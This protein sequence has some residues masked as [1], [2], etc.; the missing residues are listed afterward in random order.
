MR[1]IAR[2]DATAQAEFVRKGEITPLELVD[3]AIARIERANPVLNAVVT[4]TFERARETARGDLPDGPFRGVPFLLKDLSAAWA[5]VRQTSGSAFLRDFTPPVDSVLVERYRAAGLVFLGKTNCPEFGFLPTTE[6]ALFGATRNPWDTNR[7][8]GGSSGGSAAAVAAGMVPIA[9]G[10]DGGGSIRVPASCCGLVGLKP[11]RARITHAPLLGDIMGGLVVDHALARTVRDSAALL[12]ATAGPAPGDPYGAPPPARPFLAE[13]GADPGQL[14]IAWS[15]SNPI[16]APVHPDCIRAVEEAAA[17]CAE[18]GHDVEEAAPTVDG[19]LLYESFFAVW[20]AGHA[21]GIEG[22]ARAIGRKPEAES[23]EPLT[24]AFYRIGREIRAADYLLA[25][26]ALQGIARQVAGFL[27]RHDAWLMPTLAQ[28]PVPLG[29]FDRDS[30]EAL[31]VFRRASEFVPFTPLFNAT[32]QP[33]VS[34]PLHW[35]DSGLPI[36][37]QLA[38][39]FGDEAT[40]IRLAAA[41]EEARPWADRIPPAWAGGSVRAAGRST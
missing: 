21:W 12:D 5:G 27:A 3:A 36:G 37:V 34:L 15:A 38:G 16:G 14:R 8:P 25:V 17:L 23:F 35:N 11:T 22:M 29:T 18:L 6:P 40:L 39:R 2:L 41:L 4:P 30:T 13:V 9:H 31:E 32:G 10:N 24:W 1:E 20:L 7:T 19:D 26:T 33:A 28:P